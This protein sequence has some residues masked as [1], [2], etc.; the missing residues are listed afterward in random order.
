M[1]HRRAPSEAKKSPSIGRQ[2]QPDH[3]AVTRSVR[4]PASPRNAAPS[5]TSKW[6]LA[7]L[8]CWPAFIPAA[9]PYVQKLTQQA[10]APKLFPAAELRMRLIGIVRRF[11][12]RFGTLRRARQLPRPSRLLP[13]FRSSDNILLSPVI[14]NAPVEQVFHKARVENMERDLLRS[15][16][17]PHR[18]RSSAGQSTVLQPSMPFG[19]GDRQD[20]LDF[21]RDHRETFDISQSFGNQPRSRAEFGFGDFW[22]HQSEDGSVDIQRLSRGQRQVRAGFEKNALG[23]DG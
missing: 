18:A 17:Q 16:C 22:H 9:A 23:P 15:P 8:S 1:S 11:R 12:C 14:H 20:V 19:G 6:N 3:H 5:E 7:S 13:L 2:S 4:F 10:V 21:A